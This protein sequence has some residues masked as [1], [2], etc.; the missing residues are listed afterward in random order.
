M[1]TQLQPLF[2]SVS[3]QV[4]PEDLFLTKGSWVRF[5]DK[6]NQEWCS[7]KV[8]EVEEEPII[9]P[10]QISYVLPGDDYKDVDLSNATNGV[11]LYPE[12]EYVLYQMAVGFKP[13]DYLVHIFIPGTKYVYELGDTDMYPDVTDASK[14]YLGAKT[15]KDSPADAPLLFL[16]AIKDMAAFTFRFYV[17]E[18]V[19]YEK[20]TAA[21][22]INKCQLTEIEEP[23]EEQLE[24]ALLIRYYDELTG[25]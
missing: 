19:D 1:I 7:G 15:Y 2:K 16:Y 6:F 25:F 17:L 18:G 13:G 23:T 5:S 11:K 3:T 14:K 9:V 8:F 10:Y 24:K 20:C 21:F 12:K 4:R 22:Q